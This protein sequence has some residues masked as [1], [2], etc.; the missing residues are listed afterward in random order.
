MKIK[1]NPA[2]DRSQGHQL[3]HDYLKKGTFTL[4]NPV[5]TPHLNT[6]IRKAGMV[7]VGKLRHDLE[8]EHT[9]RCHKVLLG[10]LH[11]LQREIAGVLPAHTRNHQ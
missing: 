1:Q 10:R 5:F 4:Q 9:R 8:G 11:V 7:N 2:Y 3:P 6:H